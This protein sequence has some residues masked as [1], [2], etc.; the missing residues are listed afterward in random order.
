MTH[1]ELT[2]QDFG[3]DLNTLLKGMVRDLPE[4]KKGK[5][6]NEILKLKEKYKEL[7]EDTA[8]S[9][10]AENQD[11]GRAIKFVFKKLRI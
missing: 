3:N 9:M 11:T 1:Q 5:W 6:V 10:E 8:A 4:S 7:F 2:K